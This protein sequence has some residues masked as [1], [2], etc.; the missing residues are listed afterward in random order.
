MREQDC[1]APACQG[2]INIRLQHMP[3]TLTQVLAWCHVLITHLLHEQSLWGPVCPST[4]CPMAFCQL[5]SPGKLPMG[6]SC[7]LAYPACQLFMQAILLVQQN[8]ASEAIKVLEPL[9]KHIE[10]MQET[11]AVRVCLLLM[12]L[13]LASNNY[14][15]AASK[16][17]AAAKRHC[18]STSL[19][20]HAHWH[21]KACHP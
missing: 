19:K 12:E 6:T 7:L 16:P 4:V 11:V 15:Q 17:H 9:F 10:P 20:E 3:C 18:A 1:S 5:T 8:N 14:K 21:Q 13:Y 2:Y